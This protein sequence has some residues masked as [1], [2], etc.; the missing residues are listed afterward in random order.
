MRR[1]LITPIAL[2]A[3]LGAAC[4]RTSSSSGTLALSSRAQSSALKDAFAGAF[5]VGAALNENQ[6]TERDT[7]GVLLTK[8][9]FNTATAENVLKWERVHPQP[10]QYSFVASDQYVDFGVRN[11]MFIIG[12]TLVW[13]SQTPRWV[14][15]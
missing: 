11:G 8:R 1:E 5:R 10:D 3:L 2:I 4:T 14:F 7:L 6:F 9:H 13:H 15:Q 12:H